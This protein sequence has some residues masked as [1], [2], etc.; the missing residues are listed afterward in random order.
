MDKV[1]AIRPV[2]LKPVTIKVDERD[3]EKLSL[4]AKNELGCDRTTLI[5]RLIKVYLSKTGKR[6]MP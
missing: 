3:L 2:V 5:R 6:T 1:K 4:I